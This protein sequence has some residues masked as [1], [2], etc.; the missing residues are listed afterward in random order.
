MTKANVGAVTWIDLTV[1]D[2]E[3]LGEF[4]GEVVGW[5]PEGVEMD[6]YEDFMMNRPD[7]GECAAGI[8]HARGPNAKIPPQ[9]LVY[10]AVED[11]EA[12]AARCVE[13]GGEVVDGPRAM[14]PSRFCVVRDPAGAVLGLV[15]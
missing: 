8:C 12:S 5:R 7:D 9:W 3:R 13:L 11:V 4:Y 2:A 6:G 14:G 1:E 15:S 10:V